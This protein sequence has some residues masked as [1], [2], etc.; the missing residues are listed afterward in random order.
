MNLPVIHSRYKPDL[1]VVV[2]SDTDIF[3]PFL[4][5]LAGWGIAVKIFHEEL[6]LAA[7]GLKIIELNPG[8]GGYIGI[9]IILFPVFQVYRQDRSHRGKFYAPGTSELDA[10]VY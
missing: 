3:D 9:P 8:P 7:E 10:I 5:K 1:K 6:E 2:C 4:I